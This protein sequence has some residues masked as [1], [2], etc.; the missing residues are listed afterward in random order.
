MVGKGAQGMIFYQGYLEEH[1]TDVQVL[2]RRGGYR[3]VMARHPKS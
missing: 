2:G 1:W 3:V